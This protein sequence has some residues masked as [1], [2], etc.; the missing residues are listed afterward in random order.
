MAT[1]DTATGIHASPDLGSGDGTA[2]ETR[3]A[4]VR[5]QT[6]RE[7]EQAALAE[8]REHGPVGLSLRSVARRM[9]MSPAGLYRYVDSRE[10]LLTLLIA[11]GYEDLGHHLEVALG[12]P[13]DHAPVAARPAPDPPLVAGPSEDAADRLRAVSLAYRHWSVTHV[14]E[15]GLLF[16]DPIPGYAAPAGGPTVAGM[17]RVG[18]ALAMP[19]LEAWRAGRLRG[20]PALATEELARQLAPMSELAGELPGEVAARLLLAWGRLHGQVSLEVFGHHRW[21]FPAG[22]E[23]LYEAEVEVILTDLLTPAGPSERA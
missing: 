16:G 9:G 13:A 14:N 12:A 21:L 1:D 7:L 3:R 15:F 23:A 19:M 5:R 17:N 18:R 8:V 10:A 11:E 6:L 2:A 4:R 22:C 20:H